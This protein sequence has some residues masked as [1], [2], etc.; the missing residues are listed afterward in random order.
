MPSPSASPSPGLVPAPLDGLL[1][2][3][4][5]AA[6]WPVSVMIDDNV[7]ARPQSGFNGAS[8]VYQAPADGG[9]TKYLFVFQEG[10]A[11]DLGPVR[12]ARPYFWRWAAEYRAIFGHFGG[13]A[14]TERETAAVHGKLI[15]NVDALNG[16]GAAYHRINAREAPHNAYTTTAVLRRVG[17]RLGAPATIAPGLPTRAFREDAPLEG[18][19]KAA[20]I[21]I[22]YVTVRVGYAYDRASDSYLRSTN[23]KAQFDADGGGRVS[24]RNVVVLFMKPYVDTSAEPGHQ[25]PGFIQIGTGPALFFSEGR[26]VKGT[27]R[28]GS[29]GDLTRF[30]DA[31]G[32]EVALVRGQ[33]YI[34]VVRTD[35]KVSYT[36]TP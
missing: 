20:T 34:Q 36:T 15:Y 14:R 10:D 21:S 18:R 27:W 9:E 28:K 17:E 32:R 24:A 5:L 19:P 23:G 4:E 13:D 11:R 8:I 16:G 1:V 26:I 3:P 35:T 31:S 30:Y 33:I 6:R 2:A 29:D 12:S 22:P 25:R 7:P